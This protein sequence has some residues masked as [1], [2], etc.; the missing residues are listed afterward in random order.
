[1]GSP[2]E[3]TKENAGGIER[4]ASRRS[5]DL[6]FA[7]RDG[8]VLHVVADQRRLVAHYAQ[9]ITAAVK[10]LVVDDDASAKG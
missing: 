6:D 10:D 7:S 3:T 8:G 4:C 9:E 2:F 5:M 1:M